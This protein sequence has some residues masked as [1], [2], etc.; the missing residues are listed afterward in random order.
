MGSSLSLDKSY[1]NI[2]IQTTKNNYV[3]GD[4]VDGFVHLNLVK[5][6]PSPVLHLVISG[7]EK[8]KLVSTSSYQDS[9]GHT[10]TEVH[11]HRDKNEFFG[12]TF[13][14]YSYNQHCFP[15]GQYS[16]PF[17]FKLLETLPGSFHHGWYSHGHNC[18]GEV[19]YKLWA[20]LKTKNEKKGLFDSVDFCVD[21]R[22][23][24]STG[25][26]ATNFR[27]HMKAYCYRDLGE[28]QLSCLFEKDSFIVNENA[29]VLIGID[30]SKGK[31]KVNKIKCKL[32]QYIELEAGSHCEKIR[33]VVTEMELPGID[34]GHMRMG[35]EA[36]PVLLPIRTQSEKEATCYGS[37]VRNTFKLQI[38]TELDACF[39][40]ENHPSNDL[41]VKIFNIPMIP[42]HQMPTIP[43][44]QPQTM[45]PYVATITPEYRMTS[46]FKNDI[47]INQNVNYPSM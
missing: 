15:R 35:Q 8:T 36:I 41:D 47:E 9:E 30:N 43:N 17:S 46:E 19:F 2:F 34:A 20:G 3:A 7:E 21:Q 18:Y 4:Q 42:T 45:V 14:L 28:F 31:A 33:K 16:F 44:W 40:C 11:V 23:E 12:H 22:F 29:S 27:K 1:G 39:C 32:V 6:F 10:H 13:P 38:K 24:H 5:D 37:L 26:K 25:P